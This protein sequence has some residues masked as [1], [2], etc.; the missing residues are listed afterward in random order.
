MYIYIYISVYVY[1]YI[2]INIYV[3]VYIYIYICIY[4]YLSAPWP[5]KKA[6]RG[7]FERI[8]LR[9]VEPTEGSVT[10][11]GVDIQTVGLAR[12]RSSVTAI[13]QDDSGEIYL[14]KW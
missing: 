2:C 11:D 14:P 10:I 9:T 1:I 8:L 4:L 5:K 13:P 12:L 6:A 7:C 3:Y